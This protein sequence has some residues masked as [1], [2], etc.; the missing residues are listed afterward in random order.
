[1]R[2]ASGTF[3][4]S[5]P[6]SASMRS[7]RLPQKLI[8]VSVVALVVLSAAGQVGGVEMSQRLPMSVAMAPAVFTGEVV[9]IFGGATEGDILDTIIE[10]DPVTGDSRVLPQKLPSP[11][12]M[13]AAVWADGSA[14][15]IGGIGFDAVPLAE[16]V[17]FTP[18][19]GVELLE[20]VMPWGTKGIPAVWSG[21]DIYVLGN[22]LSSETGHYHIIRYDPSSNETEVMEDVLPIPGAGSSAVWTGEEAYIF[23]GR[24]N[25]SVLSDKVLRF[26]PGKEVE[27]MEARLP[28]G[29]IGAAAAWDGERAYAI[30]G[31]ISLECGPLECVPVDYLKEIIVYY[32]ESDSCVVHKDHLR[33][34]MDTRAAVWTG[35][36]VLVPG[37][38][39]ADG[40]EDTVLLFDHDSR[41]AEPVDATVMDSVRENAVLIIG[42]AA[43]LLMLVL[44]VA[45]KRSARPPRDDP[46]VEVGE[47]IGP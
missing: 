40:P 33:H 29:R 3:I 18:G 17:R 22:C 43:L 8:A 4:C 9:Y 5:R 23:G 39:S 13:S 31:T 44:V 11:R 41:P 19:E 10:V 27:V 7:S 37:G 24:W 16:M 30:G 32:P 38:L 34:A 46:S 2:G 6:D 15:V 26:E 35:E 1:M 20:G 45:W 42:L 47:P 36:D 14:Y 12:K 25:V 21:E 28:Q